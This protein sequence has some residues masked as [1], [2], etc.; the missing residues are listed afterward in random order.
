MNN[1]IRLPVEWHQIPVCESCG[2][3]TFDPR[4]VHD[5]EDGTPFV[6]YTEDNGEPGRDDVFM[7]WIDGVLAT[8]DVTG[9]N[10][11]IH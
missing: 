1:V 7:L 9:G 11:Q 3:R 5:P 8:G 4:T 6:V 10:V 2:R